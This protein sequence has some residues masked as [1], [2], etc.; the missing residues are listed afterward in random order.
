MLTGFHNVPRQVVGFKRHFSRQSLRVRCALS[1]DYCE[2]AWILRTECVKW[3]HVSNKWMREKNGGTKKNKNKNKKTALLDNSSLVRTAALL[4]QMWSLACLAVMHIRTLS[5]FQWL[6]ALIRKPFYVLVFFFNY[7]EVR[8][9]LFKDSFFLARV[10]LTRSNILALRN[11]PSPR[12]PHPWTRSSAPSVTAGGSWY[13]LCRHICMTRASGAAIGRNHADAPSYLHAD[14]PG[15]VHHPGHP[16]LQR[17][18]EPARRRG[19]RWDVTCIP[20]WV[21]GCWDAD[22]CLTIPAAM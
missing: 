10:S 1:V 22:R 17:P 4:T 16:L 21:D 18:G 9:R 8:D 13:P 19:W 14:V 3:A 11:P 5:G 2:G 15:H 12:F 20:E 6:Y 7:N